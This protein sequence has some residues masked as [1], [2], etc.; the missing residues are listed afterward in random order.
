MVAKLLTLKVRDG[1]FWPP[2]IITFSF[3]TGYLTLTHATDMHTCNRCILIII[4]HHFHQGGTGWGGG[5]SGWRCG[6]N[7][8]S[9]KAYSYSP[10]NHTGSPQGISLNQIYRSWF[11]YL[12]E[13]Y[14]TVNRTG[15]P[16]GISV[17]FFFY[18]SQLIDWLIDLLEAYSPVNRTG[19][20]QGF[21]LNRI[22][23]KLNTIQNIHMNTNIKHN[24]IKKL[25]PQ[26][27]SR[28]KWQ[29]KLGGDAGLFVCFIA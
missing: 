10:D 17:I 14:G 23:H 5:G 27:C 13:V 21:S 20:P 9:L 28:K 26:Y 1:F 7:D 25:V 11:I 16:Q 18:R 12:L 4:Y 19:S 15:S 6:S 22:S 24:R 8:F 2:N 29:I 3:T